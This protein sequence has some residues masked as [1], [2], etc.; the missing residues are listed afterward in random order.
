MA[1]IGRA[2]AVAG[3]G[4]LTLSGLVAWLAWL[5]VRI[6][7]LIGFRNRFLVLFQW[8]RPTSP[9]TAAPGRSPDRGEAEAD[10]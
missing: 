4:R 10:R 2:V 7:F 6:M 5:P 1:P 3:V 9:G 8:P